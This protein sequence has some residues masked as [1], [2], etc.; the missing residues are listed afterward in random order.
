MN[1]ITGKRDCGNFLSTTELISRY[2][3]TPREHVENYKKG[4]VT[5]FAPRIQNEIINLAGRK[6]RKEITTEVQKSKYYYVLF[7]TTP[8]ISRKDQSTQIIRYVKVNDTCTIEERFVDSI[9]TNEKTGV[10]P[11]EEITKTIQS[12]GLKLCDIRGQDYDNGSNMSGKYNGVQALISGKNVLARCVPCAAHTL[13]LVV[14]QAASI[15]VDVV[16]FF[17][18]TQRLFTFSQAQHNDETF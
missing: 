14:V 13:N 17:G 7:D 8:D 6:I 16:S 9:N 1:E 10:G 18:T 15:S 5:Y 12:D 11:A 4:P 2:N 3:R